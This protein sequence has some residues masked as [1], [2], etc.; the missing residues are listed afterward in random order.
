MCV[1]WC[2]NDALIYEVREEEV[3]EETKQEDLEIGLESLANKYGLDK[4]KEILTRMSAAKK[5]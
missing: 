3:D 5:G 2:L 4:I 1:Q